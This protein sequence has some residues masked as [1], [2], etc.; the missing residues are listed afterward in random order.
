MTR[1]TEGRLALGRTHRHRCQ[2]PRTGSEKHK[3]PR[4]IP[5][6]DERHSLSATRAAQAL[7]TLRGLR[8]ASGNRAVGVGGW[9][10]PNPFRTDGADFYD[11][12]HF[13]PTGTFL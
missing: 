9:G 1:T 11:R 13:S 6:A 10:R 4:R 2:R 12:T 5:P 7:R 3:P 8:S